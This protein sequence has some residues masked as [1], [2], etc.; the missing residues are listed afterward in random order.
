[1]YPYLKDESEEE[2]FDEVLDIAIKLSSKRRSTRQEAAEAL[3]KMGRK[4][5]RPLMFLLHSEYVSDGSDEEYTALCEEVEAVLV[6]IGEDALPDLNDLAT[7]TSA[8]IPVNEFAQCAIFAV[9]GLE[10]E[11]RQKVCH[12]WMRYLCQ[13]GGKELWKCWCCEAEFEYE[14]QSRAVYIRVVK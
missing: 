13:K 6:K 8:L 4:A 7:N 9:M 11:E 1:M 14:D 5:V 12:H 2:E 10:G 3:V